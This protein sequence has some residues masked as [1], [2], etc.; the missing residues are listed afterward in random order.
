MAMANKTASVLVDEPRWID[1]CGAIEMTKAAAGPSSAK[2][3]VI[4]TFLQAMRSGMVGFS[5]AGKKRR[6]DAAFWQNAGLEKVFDEQREIVNVCVTHTFPEPDTDENAGSAWRRAHAVTSIG[7]LIDRDDLADWLQRH[8]RH[9]GSTALSDLK[10][11]ER[12]RPDPAV[13]KEQI[14]DLIATLIVSDADGH[15]HRVKTDSLNDD[16]IEALP[17]RQRD[18]RE[19]REDVLNGRGKEGVTKRLFRA[20]PKIATLREMESSWSELFDFIETDGGRS[21]RGKKPAEFQAAIVAA[22]RSRLNKKI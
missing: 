4:G 9:E 6:Q 3:Y 21:G 14:K 10:S 12:E 16:H 18:L 1:I 8:L 19:N 20:N 2:G 17:R 11:G 7:T 5:G 13:R 15:S 22:A